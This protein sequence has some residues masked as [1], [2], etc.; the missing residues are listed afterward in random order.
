MASNLFV[1]TRAFAKEG[2]QQAVAVAVAD[3]LGPTRQ[4][5]GC[6][7]IDGFCSTRDS[8]LFHIHSRWE[9]EAAFDDHL[10]FPHTLQFLEAM[11]T[12][13]NQ[14]MDVTRSELLLRPMIIRDPIAS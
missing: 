1:F 11:K 10:Q 9:D 3:V 13:L 12:L 14:P 7:S 6:V 4:E 8:R 2:E 5:F